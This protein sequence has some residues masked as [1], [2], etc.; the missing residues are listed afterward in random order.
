MI[1]PDWEIFSAKFSSNKELTFEWFSYLLFCR[2]FNLPKGWF[3]FKNQS[4]IEKNPIEYDGE[5][6]GFQSKFYST[7]LSEHKDDLIETLNKVKRDY[8]ELT[9]LLFYTN[10]IWSQAHNN[11]EKR[12]TPPQALVN[13]ENKAKELGILLEWREASF[14]ESE[15]VCLEHDDLSK[16]FFTEQAQHGWQRFDDWSNTKAEIEAEYYFDDNVKVISPNHQQNNELNVVD[17]INEIRQKL[18]ST[19]TSV[20]LIGLSGVGKTRFAQAL[21]DERIG[22]N[23]LDHRNV[24][25]CDL[26]DS[27]V[28]MPEHFIE[29]LIQKNKP[30]ILIVDNCGQDT[31]ANLTRKVQNTQIA[32]MTIEYDVKDD[33]PERTDVYKLKPISVEI[34]QKVIERHYS[35]INSLNSRKIAEFAGGNY[36]LALA[37][38]SNIERTDN[39]ALLTDKELFERLFWQQGHVDTELLK[40]AQNFALVYSFNIEDS[41][42][43]NSELDFLARLARV[44]AEIA[45]EA[46]ETLKNKDIV[47]HRGK[48]RA[49]LPHALANHLAKELISTK[50]VNKIDEFT[51]IMPTRLQTSFIKRLSYL[52]DV[53]R[54][55]DVVNLWLNNEGWLG[56]KILN[57]TYDSQDLV[58]IRLLSF[59][60]EDQLLAL[61]EQKHAL[62]KEF[63]TRENTHF[64]ELSR[65]IRS[66][67]YQ[68]H[69]FKKAFQLLV[70]F[71]KDEKE[72][73]NYNS[74]RD[75]VTSLFRLYTSETLA[76]LEQKKEILNELKSQEE[77]QSIL[78]DCISTAL[79][80]HE[81]GYFI[82]ES[83]E[84]GKHSNYGYQPKTYDEIWSWVK[85]LLEI[86]NELDNHGVKKVRKIFIDHLKE[87]IWTCGEV[88]IVHSILEKFHKRDYFFEAH[89]QLINI[90][91]LN[92]EELNEHAPDI[93]NQLEELEKILRPQ[94]SNIENLIK[95]YLLITDTFLYKINKDCD[96]E[97][98]IEIPDF[99]NYENL[100]NYLSIQFKNIENL[101]N[102]ISLLLN[103]KSIRGKVNYTEILGERIASRLESL[104]ECIEILNS[105]KITEP[106][107]ESDLLLGIVKYFKKKS[108]NEYQHLINF[109]S[110]NIK[111]RKLACRIIFINCSNDEDYQY[112]ASLLKNKEIY[113]ENVIG[114]AWLKA[115]NQI[116]EKQFE[117]ILDVLIDL[118]LHK[119]VQFELFQECSFQ[120]KVSTKYKKILIKHLSY[121]ISMENTYT[122]KDI[123]NYL[124]TSDQTTIN[125][126]FKI[127]INHYQQQEYIN[128][129]NNDK[130]FNTLKELITH[131][132]LK[133][134]KEF[135]NEEIFRKFYFN[136]LFNILPYA[137]EEEVLQWIKHDQ[138]KLIFWVE[139]SSFIVEEN[140]IDL[141]IQILDI[142]ENPT[143]ILEK[144]IKNN[145]FYTKTIEVRSG[146]I[147]DNMRYKLP[148]LASLKLKLKNKNTEILSLIDKKEQEWIRL[149]EIQSQKDEQSKRL[150]SEIFPW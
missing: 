96:D 138:E 132:T 79:N 112:L 111:Y 142:S 88:S 12:M 110:S 102:N 124:L 54:V 149:I 51:K 35:H 106:L 36:R 136:G 15:F 76:D 14:F 116:S 82:K 53:P 38:A 141:I 44:D 47:Q 90:I 23:S 34:V 143:L 42:E 30:Y 18:S 52:H 13:I 55:K 128:I 89:A 95:S 4:G 60:A 107:L 6:I 16:Y 113:C 146:N 150:E 10:Q 68:E 21:F 62:D 65:L 148:Y 91:K 133:F 115:N 31:H 46:I 73:E 139:N 80:F 61:I 11:T 100:I 48:W 7:K 67:A 39:L 127:I 59:I 22:E 147:S 8:P 87:I 58:K 33:L 121:F 43:E 81:Y 9:K 28:P 92:K 63:L 140:W 97:F 3:G 17:G 49:I 114:L 29:E 19:G 26:G 40:V 122:T 41:G 27:P 101:K 93:L 37:I 130:N 129:S 1:K 72:E 69:N 50:L 71:A 123:L 57:D 56:E 126:T 45:I 84:S 98:I 25:Y 109:I 86:L 144:I 104:D 131:Q 117:I 70:Y 94:N 145:V 103:I 2:E 99:D 64:V 20:R 75:L 74:I 85:F 119:I 137:K 135:C 5:I 83:D 32:L 118:N 120:K 125:K 77:Y 78:L 134:I 105:A 24:W 66:L 108:E